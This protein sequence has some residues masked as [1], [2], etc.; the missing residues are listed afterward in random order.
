MP[1]AGLWRDMW[2]VEHGANPSSILVSSYRE[3]ARTHATGNLSYHARGMAIDIGGPDMM[4]YFQW[5]K[6]HYPNSEEIIYSPAGNDQVHNGQP[7]MYG[8]PTR[9]DHWTHVH[10]GCTSL[11]KAEQGGSANTPSSTPAVSGGS[12]NPDLDSLIGFLS[13]LTDGSIWVRLGLFLGGAVLV[14]LFVSRA[15]D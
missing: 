3:G 9:G 6:A 15:G 5:I 1:D 10:W 11:Q 14:I 8:E 2:A 12:G 4:G 13:A 7:H